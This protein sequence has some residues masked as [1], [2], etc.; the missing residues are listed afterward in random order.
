MTTKIWNLQ[1]LD[2]SSDRQFEAHNIK[3]EPENLQPNFSKFK[4]EIKRIQNKKGCKT[5]T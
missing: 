1:I 5:L 3:Y 2:K 4:M